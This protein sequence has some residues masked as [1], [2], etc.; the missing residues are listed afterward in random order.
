MVQSSLLNL[1]FLSLL[2]VL[3]V[4]KQYLYCS[5]LSKAAKP[6]HTV[7][8]FADSF[9]SKVASIRTATDGASPLTF[10]S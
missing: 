4:N 6:M 9:D 3:Y 5:L 10:T 1:I 8:D 2:T 7:N